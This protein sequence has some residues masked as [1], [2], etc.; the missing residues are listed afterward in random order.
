MQSLARALARL[1]GV[2][3]LS[4]PWRSPAWPPGS[5]PDFVNAAAL[6]AGPADPQA[7]LARLHGVEAR[8]GRVRDRRWGPRVLDL[9]LLASGGLVRPDPWAQRAWAEL[10]PAAQ[11]RVAPD[12]LILPH[13]RLADRGFVLA[14]LAEIAPRWRHPVTG[15]SVAAMW[16][17][18]PL[19]RRAG[20]RPMVWR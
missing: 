17:A 11:A 16:A 19:E 12:R 2:R 10:A 13:P 6:V 15:R 3:R 8:A 18:L 14:P 7:M 4:R 5:G 9:D 20:L 1:G